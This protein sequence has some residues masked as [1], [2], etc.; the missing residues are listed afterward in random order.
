[1]SS[2]IRNELRRRDEKIDVVRV[3]D[4][5]VPPFGTPDETIL[6]WIEE[7]DYVSNP[8]SRS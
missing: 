2:T 8:N 6:E 7:S 3:G 5:N 1:M 4:D